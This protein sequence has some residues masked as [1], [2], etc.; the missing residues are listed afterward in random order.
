MPREFNAFNQDA[1]DNIKLRAE[2]VTLTVREWHDKTG[3]SRSIILTRLRKGW[4]PKEAIS[5]AES[6]PV[7]PYSQVS[8]GVEIARCIRARHGF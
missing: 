1:K 4:P 6:Y 3:L 2:G 5:V 7:K 8:R